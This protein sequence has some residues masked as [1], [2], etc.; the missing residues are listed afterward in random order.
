MRTPLG[1]SPHT[2]GA[3]SP[4]PSE[5][6]LVRII[7]AYAGS[8]IVSFTTK[9]ASPGSSP[10]T[11]GARHAKPPPVVGGRIIPAYAGSTD[12]PHL[13]FAV[14]RDHPRIRGE[15][16]SGPDDVLSQIGSSPHTRGARCLS[17]RSWSPARIIPAYAG[18]TTKCSKSRWPKTDHPRIRGEHGL[19]RPSLRGSSGSSPHTRGAPADSEPDRGRQRIIPAYAGSTGS[20]SIRGLLA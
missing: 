14:F 3:R 9:P 10:H 17:A 16:Q 2:R 7:P 8:T 19:V 15:H 4:S 13:S 1:S 20:S 12:H 6:I 18:S 11:R 5:S